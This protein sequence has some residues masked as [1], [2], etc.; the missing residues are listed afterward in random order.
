MLVIHELM[1]TGSVEC[2]PSDFFLQLFRNY[3]EIIFT[4]ISFFQM[5]IKGGGGWKLLQKFM[6][7]GG[8]IIRYS[9]IGSKSSNI[10]AEHGNTFCVLRPDRSHEEVKFQ[11]FFTIVIAYINGTGAA[12]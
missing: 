4:I 12:I 9:R 6:S 7:G 1:N 5:F 8:A 3:V 11:R 10:L 2:T